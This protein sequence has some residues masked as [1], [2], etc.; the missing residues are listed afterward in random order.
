MVTKSI[1]SRI[2]NRGFS[3]KE[4]AF[5]RDQITNQVKPISDSEMADK[6]Y[7]QRTLQHPVDISRSEQQFT[8]GENVFIKEDKSKLRGREMYKIVD[9]F[10]ESNECW[11]TLQKSDSQFRAKDYK[12]KTS[13][14][15]SVPVPKLKDQDTIEL[16]EEAQDDSEVTEPNENQDAPNLVDG[17]SE[18][19]DSQHNPTDP[20]KSNETGR[21]TRKAAQLAR[22]KVKSW[23][24]DGLLK[25]AVTEPKHPLPNHAWDWEAFRRLVEEDDDIIVHRKTYVED[26]LPRLSDEEDDRLSWDNSPEQYELMTDPEDEDFDIIIE[27]TKLFDSTEGE[28]SLTSTTSDDEV[29][30][31]Y[32]NPPK[33]N[34]KLKRN[35][36]VRRPKENTLA[37]KSSPLG[38]V[39][40][41]TSSQVNL[42]QKQQLNKVLPR[43]N[44][45]VTEAVLLGPEVQNFQTALA[46][47]QETTTEGDVDVEVHR[48]I[49]IDVPGEDPAQNDERQLRRSARLDYKRFHLFGDKT[50]KP[51]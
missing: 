50:S 6:Q 35:L 41:E 21:P 11:A 12:V 2:R 14:I 13:E 20:T 48:E 19:L 29:F 18:E 40:P 45:L 39:T 47:L 26:I 49:P 7:K 25:V 27:P 5:Q 34:P 22:G 24:S 3:S 32:Q 38:L 31:N 51:E 17:N 1:N 23:A 10:N 42:T 15:F 43:R 16:D 28:E 4:I 36:E 37:T 8:V 46:S 30:P 33:S 9:L 44:P